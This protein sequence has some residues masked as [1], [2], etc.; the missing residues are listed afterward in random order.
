MSIETIGSLFSGIGG[1][2][3]GLERALGART[4]WQVES[5]EYARRVLSKHWPDA[6][7]YNDVR[8]VG[9]HNL[10]APDLLCGGFPCV[11]LSTAGYGGGINGERSGLWAEFSRIIRELRPSPRIVVVENVAAMLVRGNGM[12]RVVGDLVESGYLCRWDCIPASAVGA[13]HRRDRVFIVAALAD[14]V[15]GRLAGSWPE[16]A[17]CDTWQRGQADRGG[18]TKPRMGRADHGVSARVDRAVE[19][20]EQGLP[21]SVHTCP[22]R[23]DRLRCLGN[24]VVPQVAELV[25]RLVLEWMTPAPQ[26]EN[27]A[28]ART[29]D[30]RASR[31]GQS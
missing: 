15:R 31:P 26:S 30:R 29:A 19:P 4:I 11:D 23:V 28:D 8:E 22:H 14:A 6:R 13:P 5:N 25:G 18:S 20:W 9:R 10:D 3:L 16:S 27:R 21:R 24:A 12:G 1:L 17:H 2:E 7:R